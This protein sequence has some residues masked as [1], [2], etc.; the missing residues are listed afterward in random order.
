MAE[1][2]LFGE[3]VI[4]R[5]STNG[6]SQYSHLENRIKEEAGSDVLKLIAT[7]VDVNSPNTQV[8]STSTAFNIEKFEK[9][10]ISSVV[11]LKRI[12][13]LRRINK[14]FEAINENISYG[15]VFIG[16]VETLELRKERLLNKF[17]GLI[18]R[19]YLVGDYVFKRV[20]PKLPLTKQAYFALTGGRNRIL[21][22]AETL[23]RLYSC[24]FEVIHEETHGYLYY[25]VAR[26]IKPPYY[27]MSPSYGPVFAMERSGKNGKVIKV[28]K[29]R[30]MYPYS[31]YL[32]KYVYDKN[33]LESGGK[34][35]NDFRI[36]AFGKFMRKFWLDELPMLYNL[37]KL[38][39]KL[40]G[41][42][43]LS[44][45]YQSLYPKEFLEFRQRFKPGL[46]PPYYA[47]MPKS[48]EEILESERRYLEAYQK[49]S[50]FTDCIYFWKAFVN[51]VFRN[52]RSQ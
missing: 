22:R 43:P 40:V 31:E 13:D 4:K 30:T 2:V 23:G 18:N 3:E 12:N 14:F 29:F 19:I 26:K 7:Y 24:G 50:F 9:Q 39:L 34:F 6:A 38:E 46:V 32:Q 25:F 16:C 28:L 48:F 45:H 21:S 1:K 37:F 52:A 49:F 33:S 15:T 20:L 36:T 35:K 42:R 10:S 17:P 5:I 27:D 47:D 44:R 51:I 41:V 8:F 11:N